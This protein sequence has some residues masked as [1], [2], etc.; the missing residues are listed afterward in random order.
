MAKKVRLLSTMP[1]YPIKE[2]RTI[3][4][5]AT[6]ETNAGQVVFRLGLL[7]LRLTDQLC[8]ITDSNNI[9]FGEN[10]EPD[11]NGAN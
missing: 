6:V 5:A 11:Q 9:R 3:I 10:V 7:L 4:A 2:V 8:A 1:E